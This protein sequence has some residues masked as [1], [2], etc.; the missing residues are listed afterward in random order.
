MISSRS[1]SVL[2]KVDGLRSTVLKE[3][4]MQSLYAWMQIRRQKNSSWSN[5]RS[6]SNWIGRVQLLIIVMRPYA[7]GRD[8]VCD[9][10][11]RKVMRQ[12]VVM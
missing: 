11:V 4:R 5:K 2:R 6:S 12:R 7:A 8:G 1:G 3:R 10:F 9:Y